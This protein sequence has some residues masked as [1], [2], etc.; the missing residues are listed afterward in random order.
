MQ[1]Y[2]LLKTYSYNKNINLF[3]IKKIIQ[4]LFN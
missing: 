4:L 2:L 1:Q 3:L